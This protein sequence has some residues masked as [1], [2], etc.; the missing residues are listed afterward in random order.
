MTNEA[1]RRLGL[2][3][4]RLGGAPSPRRLAGIAEVVEIDH[5]LHALL[6]GAAYPG[7]RPMWRGA[8]FASRS[9]RKVSGRPR[10][11]CWTWWSRS[12]SEPRGLRQLVRASK[13]HD[14]HE[15]RG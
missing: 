1:R 6:L 10:S 15:G 7:R 12:A 13:A 5:E 14:R 2:L 8:T 4:R 11:V 3:A 9:V